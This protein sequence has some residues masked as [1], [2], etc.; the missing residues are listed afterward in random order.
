MLKLLSSFALNFILR[1]YVKTDVLAAMADGANTELDFNR[2]ASHDGG[3]GSG[4]GGSSRFSAHGDGGAG[5]GDDGNGD[6]MLS[7]RVLEMQM[8]RAGSNLTPPPGT[9]ACEL[10]PEVGWPVLK[11]PMGVSLETLISYS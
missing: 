6:G 3:G 9:L 10:T 8:N 1:R 5:G 4:G 7:P 2:R 11:A